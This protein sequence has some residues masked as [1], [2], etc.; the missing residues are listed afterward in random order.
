MV[1]F[2]TFTLPRVQSIT[3]SDKQMFVEKPLPDRSIAYRKSVAGY[4]RTFVVTGFLSGANRETDRQTLMG[5]ADGTARTFDEEVSGAPTVT[6]IM[7][8][9]QISKTVD[10]WGRIAY[11]VT[12]VQQSN[13]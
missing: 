1:K 12:F 11:T 4:G 2:G 9:P 6:C 3:D 5:L 10:K 13:P 7:L 8:D